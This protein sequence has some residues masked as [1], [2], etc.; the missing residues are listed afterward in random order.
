MA[1]RAE[2][3]HR[4][5]PLGPDRRHAGRRRLLSRIVQ[6]V[7]DLPTFSVDDGFAYE[8]PDSLTGV[9][10]G[11]IVRVPLGGRRVRGYVVGTRRRRP[12]RPL[13]EVAGLSADL[14]VFDRP[15]LDVARWASA[16]YVTPLASVLGLCTPPNLPRRPAPAGDLPPV[17][18]VEPPRPVPDRMLASAGTTCVVEGEAVDAVVAWAL[19]RTLTTRNALVVVPTVEEAVRL[20]DGLRGAFGTR[21]LLAHSGMDAK[22]Q[23]AVWARAATCRGVALV[24]TRE[25]AFWPGG[26]I[27]LG[28]IVDDGR[29]PLV[30]PR[31]PT[32]EAREVMRRRAMA[33]RFPL[34]LLGAV[35]TT[36][37]LGAGAAVH[38]PPGRI[39]P[40]VEVADRGEEPPGTG[41]VMERTRAAIRGVRR[42]G[43]MVFVLTRRR[44]YAPAFR[45]VRC[46]EVRRC[47]ACG[48]AVT[49]DRCARCGAEVGA[50]PCGGRRFEALGAAV[51]R[52]VDDLR[53]SFGAEVAAAGGDAPIR[54]G[55]ER[56]LVGVGGVELAVCIDTDAFVLAPSYRAGEDAL[57]IL[58]RLALA[59][60][61][62]RGR[63]CLVQTAMP[64]HPAV[65]ALRRGDPLPFLHAELEE[66]R[67]TGMPPAGE[68]LAVEVD[69]GDDV[70]GKLRT[71]VGGDGEVLGPATVG[72]RARWLVR[73]AE[74]DAVRLR[75]RAFVGTL[76]DAGVTVRVDV[77]PIDG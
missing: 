17:P 45:C 56:D 76:R 41:V 47:P 62:G 43:G 71:L 27:G 3:R 33:A 55:T 7:P 25:V 2:D 1:G 40:V 26:D 35:P 15:L 67:R 39:W 31:M 6:V 49:T 29:R 23:T 72:E 22:R 70:D 54:V 60:A 42:R 4:A 65:V 61:P 59:V 36:A 64:R 66:R 13:R 20:A 75:L 19:S 74:L 37:A 38:R 14:P 8:V 50:C 57:R 28:I 5:S 24:G 34:L 69:G 73:G 11:A 48:A 77:D 44:G 68:L 9:D 53:R 63:R 10:L 58:A 16:H 51:G 21:V 52:I 12:G 30:S 18:G 46:G 32:F